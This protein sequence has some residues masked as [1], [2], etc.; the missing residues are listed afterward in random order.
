MNKMKTFIASS[1][2]YLTIILAL[3]F[4]LFTNAQ[5]AGDYAPE[6]WTFTS[7]DLSGTPSDGTIDLTNMPMG[8]T[9]SGNDDDLSAVD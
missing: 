6:N 1:M 7:Q 9:M 2:S 3:A 8:F 4:P 5:F